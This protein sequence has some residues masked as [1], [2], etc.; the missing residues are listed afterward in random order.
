MGI[1]LSCGARRG[2][3]REGNV[4]LWGDHV[5]QR[6][7]SGPTVIRNG[8][9]NDDDDEACVFGKSSDK[10]SWGRQVK[11]TVCRGWNGYGMGRK[12]GEL[13]HRGE[14]SM[15]MGMRDNRTR[16]VPGR[17]RLIGKRAPGDR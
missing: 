12:R 7:Q 2:P 10:L 1:Q 8:M 9:R 15:G 3:L 4:A 13:G 16:L 5:E 6:R 14:G 17:S 11:E